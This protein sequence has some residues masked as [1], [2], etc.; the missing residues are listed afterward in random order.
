M[1]GT[2]NNALPGPARRP[3]PISF[4]PQLCKCVTL[5]NGAA[6][7][8]TVA[9]F[10]RRIFAQR[11]LAQ[12]MVCYAAGKAHWCALNAEGWA[13][14]NE[15]HNRPRQP[16]LL[17]LQNTWNPSEVQGSVLQDLEKT[18]YWRT[19]TRHAAFLLGWDGAKMFRSRERSFGTF[20]GACGRAFLATGPPLT[21]R[22]WSPL[23]PFACQRF[24]GRDARLA[25]R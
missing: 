11:H 16:V 3:L 4:N 7:H 2:A 14:S 20:A 1:A 19:D 24:R 25:Q 15:E 18:G 23:I 12:K 13:G 10:L 6:E 5:D 8:S 17:F 9:G 22:P 21:I